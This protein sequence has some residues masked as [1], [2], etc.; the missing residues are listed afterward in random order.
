MKST[1]VKTAKAEL[2]LHYTQFYS[3]I[4]ESPF[5]S[6]LRRDRIFTKKKGGGIMSESFAKKKKKWQNNSRVWRK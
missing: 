1:L 4:Y 6:K 2:L 3:M 5:N